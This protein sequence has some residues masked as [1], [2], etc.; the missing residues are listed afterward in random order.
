[1]KRAL[2]ILAIA[3]L[4]LGAPAIAEARPDHHDRGGQARS[5]RQVRRPERAGPRQGRPPRPDRGPQ[6]RPDGGFRNR[7][8]VIPPPPQYRPRRDSLGAGWRQQ[9]EEARRAVRSGR[10][11]PL[12]R[13]VPNLK[14][15]YPGR[16]LDAGIEDDWQGRPVY[17]VRWAAT[18]GRR[19]D[20]IVDA[21]TG[22]ILDAQGQ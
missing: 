7:P 18:N 10:F 12:S 14:R 19:I 4:A 9:Q 11:V 13:V 1:M 17:R 22:A 8:D 15:R 5:E 6:R 2:L 3:T 16:Q 21:Q 20:F